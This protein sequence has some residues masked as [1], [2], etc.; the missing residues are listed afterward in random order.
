MSVNLL[1]PPPPVVRAKVGGRAAFIAVWI[2][3]VVSIGIRIQ[4]TVAHRHV[5]QSQIT[6][7]KNTL[8]ELNLQ[9]ATLRVIRRRYAVDQAI[10]QAQAAS[11]NPV[12]SMKTFLAALPASAT[13]QSLTYSNNVIS[14]TVS[15]V[16]LLSAA[17]SIGVL[18]S[19][20]IYVQPV[21][22]GVSE[23]GTAGV[24][25]AFSLTLVSIRGSSS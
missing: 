3:L 24:S 13:I 19:D 14:A 18:Q 16:S 4:S 15:F 12:P 10:S 8:H 22:T 6:V 17:A 7:A 20:A 9:W 23:S 1:P 11:V 21:V 25:V 5:L 2:L